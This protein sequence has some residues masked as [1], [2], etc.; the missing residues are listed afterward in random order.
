MKKYFLLLLFIYSINSFS[1]YTL[2]GKITDIN[3]NEI[4]GVEIH[5]PQ[6]H[7]GTV[8]D[9]NGNYSFQNLPKGAFKISILY[10][11]YQTLIDNITITNNQV[12]ISF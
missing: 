2:S 9:I 10:M 1:Q 3:N 8:S 6:I 5:L 11:G 4:S 12:K 7:K